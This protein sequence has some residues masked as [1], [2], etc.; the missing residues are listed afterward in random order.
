ME[1]DLSASVGDSGDVGLI[2][3]SGRSSGGGNGNPLQ[4]PIDRGPWWATVHRVPESGK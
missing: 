2:P 4:Y 3:G 1:R